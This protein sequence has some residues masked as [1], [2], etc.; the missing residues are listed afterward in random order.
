MGTS[1]GSLCVVAG[2]TGTRLLTGIAPGTA[3]GLDVVCAVLGTRALDGI[4]G[5][6]TALLLTTILPP[7]TFLLHQP[8]ALLHLHL[9]H[10]LHLPQGW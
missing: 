7:E 1:G 8:E 6:G 10:A 2:F 9:N 5:P 3:L 4:L